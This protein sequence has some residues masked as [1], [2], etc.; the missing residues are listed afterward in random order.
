VELRAFLLKDPHRSAMA[1][2]FHWCDEAAVAHWTVESTD[3]PS[4]ESETQLLL[5]K[6]RL[7]RVKVPSDAQREGRINVA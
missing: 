1:K 2:L 4:W 6:G 5:A 7:S 3:L